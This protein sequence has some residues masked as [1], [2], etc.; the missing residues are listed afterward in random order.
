[1]KTT[2]IIDL[3]Y[4]NPTYFKEYLKKIRETENC[5]YLMIIAIG[6]FKRDGNF[7]SYDF[8]ATAISSPPWVC[9]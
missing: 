3:G 6:D 5:D 8:N 7:A 2:A 9:G 1:M 4:M